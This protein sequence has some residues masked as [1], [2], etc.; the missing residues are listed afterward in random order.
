MWP[1]PRPTS[2]FQVASWFIQLSGHNRHEPK[3]GGCAPFLRQG[4]LRSHLTQCR[5]GRGL[6]PYHMA[7]W[8]IEAFGH[9]RYGPKIVG[10]PPPFVG[11]ELGPCLTQCGQGWGLPARQGSSWLIQSFW[12]QYTNVTDRTGQTDNGSIRQANRFT[13]VRPKTAEQVDLPFGLWTLMS[14]KK[15]KFNRIRQVVPMCIISIVFAR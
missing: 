4:E 12:P 8:S 11:G 13:N 3:I 10:T 1:G 15:H 7:S 5:L 9:N 2:I 14:R 6:P